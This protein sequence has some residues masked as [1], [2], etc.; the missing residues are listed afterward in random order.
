MKNERSRTSALAEHSS[1]T[2]HQVCLESA[3]IIA[4]EEQRHKRKIREALEII[5][6]PHNLNRDND[7]EISGSWLPLIRKIN[8]LPV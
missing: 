4:K 1:K 7:M 5:K 3:S 8:P 6:H 2:K